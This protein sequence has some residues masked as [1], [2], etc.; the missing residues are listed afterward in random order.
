MQSKVPYF[1]VRWRQGFR[2]CDAVR[3]LQS[4]LVRLHDNAQ[5][6][7]DAMLS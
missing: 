7:A 3:H 5:G 1:C 6:M 2:E 4:M